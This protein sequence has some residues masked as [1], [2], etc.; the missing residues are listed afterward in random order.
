MLRIVLLMIFGFA[1]ASS[2]LKALGAATALIACLTN[3]GNQTP[4]ILGAFS[5]SIVGMLL[6][7]WLCR[8]VYFMRIP[9]K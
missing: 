9:S 2:A 3:G 6:F 4:E 7:G 1:L 5:A 8:K